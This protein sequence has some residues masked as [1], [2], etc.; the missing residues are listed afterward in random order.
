MPRPTFAAALLVSVGISLAGC[1]G[2]A[3]RPVRSSL[4][5]PICFECFW[6]SQPAGLREELIAVYEDRRYDDPLAEGERRLILGRTKTDPALVCEAHGVF[7]AA[8]LEPGRAYWVR[9]S[10]DARIVLGAPARIESRDARGTQVRR[11][12]R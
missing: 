8:T 10:Q 1:A 11:R 12:W 9:V 2:R 5:P 3:D 7:A 4:E 6:D